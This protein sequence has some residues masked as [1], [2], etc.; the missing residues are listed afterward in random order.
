MTALLKVQKQPAES[1]GDEQMRFFQWLWTIRYQG[2]HVWE[3]A[4]A[5]PNGSFLERR[6]ARAA[7][8]G[9]TLSLRGVKAGYPD[10]GID[11]AVHPYHG[12]RIEFK[13]IG[14]PDPNDKQLNWHARLRSQGYV[15]EVCYGCEA[16]KIPTL[17]YFNLLQPS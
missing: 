10:V 8:E 13:R 11:I 5:I 4:Y 16:A 6:Q 2:L 7:I 15:V 9:R 12:F 14:A 3:Y 1:E 17:R